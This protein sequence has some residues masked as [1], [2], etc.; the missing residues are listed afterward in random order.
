MVRHVE[1]VIV[2][3]DTGLERKTE[4]SERGEFVF[5]GLPPARLA[6]LRRAFADTMKD[7]GFLADTQK[8]MLEVNPT[9]GEQVDALLKKL[10]SYPKDVI[11]RAA[12]ARK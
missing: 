7:P 2:D 12:A 8:A 1:V 3:P 9:T 4:T 11:D 6:T 10:H 5:P